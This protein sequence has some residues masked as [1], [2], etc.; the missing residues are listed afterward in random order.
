[1]LVQPQKC[2]LHDV[3]CLVKFSQKPVDIVRERVLE[4]PDKHHERLLIPFLEADD[5]FLVG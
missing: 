4:S 5:K 1:M 2:L 3:I